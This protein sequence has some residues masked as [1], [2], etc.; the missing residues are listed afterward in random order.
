VDGGRSFESIHEFE[1]PKGGFSAVA[2]IES[3]PEWVYLIT[4]NKSGRRGRNSGPQSA[5]YL[6]KDE[7]KTW[8]TIQ[9]SVEGIG[10]RSSIYGG[11]PTSWLHCFAVNPSSPNEMIVAKDTLSE[12]V[13]GGKRWGR[14]T[15]NLR[16]QVTLPDGDAQLNK[17]A[18]HVADNH[19]IKFHPKYKSRAYRAC[20]SGL[21]LRDPE[22]G[23]DDWLGITGDMQ[24]MLFYSVKVNEFGDRYVIGN[25]QD[26]NV[27]S[28]QYGE[29]QWVRGYEGDVV[30]VHPYTNIAYFPYCGCGDANEIKGLFDRRGRGDPSIT[31]W[32]RPQMT[33][34]YRNPDESVILYTASRGRGKQAFH[35]TDRTLTAEALN[36]PTRSINYFNISR[37][38]EERFTAVSANGV[39]SSSDKGKTWKTYTT[40]AND[41]SFGAV[42]SDNPNRI[43]LGSKRGKVFESTDGGENW[44][45]ISDGLPDTSVLKLLYH[46]GSPRDLYVLMAKGDGQFMRP[47]GIY[48][49]NNTTNKWE[50]W[51]EGY[52][53]N[54]FSDMV[55]DYPSQKMLASSY[56]RGIWEA[57]LVGTY[58][59]FLHGEI[60]I[61]E[62]NS[63][64]DTRTFAINTSYHLPEYYNYQWRVNGVESGMNSMLFSSQ[65]L[66]END[67]VSCVLSP[68][69]SSDIVLKSKELKL[70]QVKKK[71]EVPKVENVLESNGNKVDLGY[72]DYFGANQDFTVGFRLKPSSDGVV[73]GNRLYN[74]HDA[75]GWMLVVEKGSLV[76][77]YSAKYNPA[78]A[79]K[80]RAYRTPR[81]TEQLRFPIKQEEWNEVLISFDRDG[82]LRAFLDGK[83][84]AEKEMDRSES[85]VSLNSLFNLHLFADASGKLPLQ[86]EIDD[87]TIWNKA[88]NANQTGEAAKEHLILQHSFNAS[89]K[90]SMKERFTGRALKP[91][92]KIEKIILPVEDFSSRN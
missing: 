83:L 11:N 85:H 3:E 80:A 72:Y 91:I 42:D 5:L 36:I 79:Y 25:T 43:W 41:I 27:E 49:L 67:V 7:G 15:Y 14:N 65:K 86:G 39:F 50:R 88:I 92:N 48:H 32:G 33:V 77:K 18:W 26:V 66:K 60:E 31:S 84:V 61:T 53:L 58:E 37:T 70:N 6:S 54:G 69:Y 21:Y 81:L 56:G 73:V 35:I 90:D 2:T 24:A 52:T 17:Y 62:I 76:L 10:Q 8:E 40:P 9:N 78:G 34:N 22:N 63:T 16:M 59:R 74:D 1:D 38:Q 55:I 4:T 57:D 47:Y 44:K 71:M 23:I 89:T 87:L 20:D 13:D 82:Q 46:E 19:V 68:R 64:E 45:T 75:K 12:S 51:M 29:W 30:L 28:Y